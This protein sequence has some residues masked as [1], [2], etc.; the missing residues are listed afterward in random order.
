[1]WAHRPWVGR[2]LPADTRPGDELAAYGTWCNAVEGNTTFYA[3]P[4]PATVARWAEAMPPGFEIACKLPR[5]ITHERRLRHAEA[6]LAEALDRLAPLGEHLGPISVQLPA[7]FGPDDLAV[8]EAF[9]TDLPTD[10][11]FA[12]ELRHPGFAPGGAHER[13]VNDLL[14]RHGVDRV[15][16]DSRALFAAP[17]RTSAEREAWERK[18]RLPVRAVAIADR[19]VVRFIGQSDPDATREHWRPWVATV[20]RWIGDGRR[21]LVFLHTPDNLDSPVLARRFWLDVAEATPHLDLGPLPEPAP[22]TQPALFDSA[23]PGS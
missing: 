9:L 15:V 11:P 22:T 13:A 7:T 16:L 1:M 23:D 17:P 8:L 18:P 14:H 10:L 5:T 12:V 6:E 3:L 4:G 19:P 2:H 21:P 20:A